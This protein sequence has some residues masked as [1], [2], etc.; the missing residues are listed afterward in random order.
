MLLI[1][2]WLAERFL[3]SLLINTRHPSACVCVGVLPSKVNGNNF[4]PWWVHERRKQKFQTAMNYP[5]R[6]Y[7]SMACHPSSHTPP[8]VDRFKFVER[9]LKLASLSSVACLIKP[10]FLN[11]RDASRLLFALSTL[12]RGKVAEKS[13]AM[14]GNPHES[15]HL[16]SFGL[17]KF[18]LVSSVRPLMFAWFSWSPSEAVFQSWFFHS[19]KDKNR[20]KAK[21]FGGR[22][23]WD[24]NFSGHSKVKKNQN[25]APSR[26]VKSETLV[27]IICANIDFSV[28]V[29]GKWRIFR[30]T[31][32]RP[33]GLQAKQQQNEKHVY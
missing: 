26:M 25:F 5:R 13:F 3:E 11:S 29:Y 28:C 1:P 33:R 32:P 17:Q 4:I 22:E 12:T 6:K 23:E 15:F 31:A 19:C 18:Q 16:F 30:S 24:K 14:R 27:W 2:R 9:K 21:I 10:H 20:Q 7:R 8:R